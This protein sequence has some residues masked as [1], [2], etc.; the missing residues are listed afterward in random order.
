MAHG[1]SLR[2]VFQLAHVAGPRV[3]EQ[4][5]RDRWRQR[6]RG[7][8][9]RA[10]VAIEVVREQQQDVVVAIAKRRNEN[11]RDVQAVIQILAKISG[12]DTLTQIAIRRGNHA[13]VHLLLNPIGAEAMNLAGFQKPQQHAL[14]ARRHLAEL[15]EEQRAAVRENGESR[16]VAVRVREAAAHMAEELRLEQRVRHAGAVDGEERLAGARAVKMN[17]PGDDFLADAGFA[18]DEHFG[19]AS[20][21]RLNIDP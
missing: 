9:L 3:L 19:V 21:R 13:D 11:L 17:E 18:R 6:W 8:S 4:L 5:F 14:H 10:A 2:H 16:F 15:I 1:N 12:R 20:C 7:D